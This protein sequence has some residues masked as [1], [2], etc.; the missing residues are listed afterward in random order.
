ML[1]RRHRTPRRRLG[2][3]ERHSLVVEQDLSVGTWPEEPGRGRSSEAVGVFVDFLQN[4][5]QQSGD[6][7]LDR[8]Q[9]VWAP[10]Q[11]A[12]E[13]RASEP[14]SED[15]AVFLVRQVFLDVLVEGEPIH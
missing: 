15:G 9:P 2:G 12:Q 6:A 14:T 1:G 3:F 7:T 13:T 4:P 8:G 5:T 11:G 10:E